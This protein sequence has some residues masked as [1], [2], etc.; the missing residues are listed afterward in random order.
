MTMMTNLSRGPDRER[1]EAGRPWF[2][3]LLVALDGSPLAERSLPFARDLARLTRAE[4][5]LL[6][7]AF[8]RP[9]SS[10]PAGDQLRAVRE[11]QDYLDRLADRLGR[12]LPVECAT[13]YGSPLEEIPEVARIRGVGLVVLATHGRGGLGR[14]VL[15]SVA[16]GLIRR[17]RLPLLLVRATLPLDGWP[18]GLRRI[19]VPLD[20]SELA[21]AAL[22]P[23]AALATLAG[24]RLTLLD[25]V[26]P[27]IPE[28][29]AYEIAQLPEGDEAL[30]EQSRI[31]LTRQADALREQGLEVETR[32][33]FGSPA[34]QIVA[35]ASEGADLIAMATHA[36]GGLDRL[37]VGS[38][39]DDVLHTA[40]VPL[41]LVR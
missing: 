30:A 8:V 3:R 39:A 16:D 28:L 18:A 36:R 14:L 13:P 25:V 15:G 40:P 26:G 37:V 38:V 17:T 35:A 12:D 4:L 5:I 31:Y 21:A 10:D 29:R 2:G 11:A 24:A 1:M 20:G 33:A 27:A 41:L 19:L 34:A 22:A 32:V 23:A 6:R 9:P 7:A